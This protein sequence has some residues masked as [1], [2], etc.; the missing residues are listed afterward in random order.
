MALYKDI[1]SYL[2]YMSELANVLLH[3]YEKLEETT[4]KFNNI[5]S[6]YNNHISRDNLKLLSDISSNINL[7][8]GQVDELYYMMIDNSEIEQ[9]P[10]DKERIKSIK[11]NNMIQEKITPLIFYMKLVLENE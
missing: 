11:I 9:S 8:E 7:L 6:I 5:T 3:L 1:V 10:L 2:K 4:D